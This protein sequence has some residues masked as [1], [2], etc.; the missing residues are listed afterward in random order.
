MKHKRRIDTRE[1]YKWKACL[2]LDGSKQIKGVNYWETYA[3]VTSWPTVRLILT[4]AIIQ[5]WHT[6]QLDFVLAF[7]Q[8]PVEIGNL[9]MQVPPRGFHVPGAVSSNNYVY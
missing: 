4:M 5:G 7:T 6:K 1:I 3:P 9:Y 2:N 8:A